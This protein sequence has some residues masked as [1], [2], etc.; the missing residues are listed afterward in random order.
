MW[1][2]VT[3]AEYRKWFRSLDRKVQARLKRAQER[4]EQEG[5][6]LG[7]PMADPVEAAA[8]LMAGIVLWLSM[9]ER[10]RKTG[11]YDEIVTLAMKKARDS[12]LR[13]MGLYARWRRGRW[14]GWRSEKVFR[15]LAE[16]RAMELCSW[17]TEG[18][19]RPW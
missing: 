6:N 16:L 13:V 15:G 10:A 2:V 12:E 7:R 18:G 1:E 8:T 3:T 9:A 14:I 11:I 19:P 4:L 17:T 5:P